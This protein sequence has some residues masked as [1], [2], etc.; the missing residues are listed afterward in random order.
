MFHTDSTA[1]DLGDGLSVVVGRLPAELAWSP[2]A[3]R[4]AW[5]LHPEARPTIFL[6]GREVTVPRWQQ[7]YGAD[8]HFSGQVSR[9][10]P[11]PPPLRPLL[12]W[13]RA[14]VHPA[15]NGLLLNWYDGPGHYIGPHHD[16]TANMVP[17]A[18][19]VTISFGEART[20]RMSLGRQKRDFL[21]ADG[22]VIVIPQA[23]NAVWKHAVP[24]SA[25]YAGRRISVTVRAFTGT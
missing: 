16:S 10:L 12:D 7:A 19:I 14:A 2:A 1:H 6:H 21:A 20:F 4:E 22:C 23:T 11:V 13:A 25:R 5:T 15:L 17:A 24:K 18:P 9:S 3:F 8:Y